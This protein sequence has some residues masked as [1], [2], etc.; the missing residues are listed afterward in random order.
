M[1]S[2]PRASFCALSQQEARLETSPPTTPALRRG[3]DAIVVVVQIP[4]RGGPDR[5]GGARAILVH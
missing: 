4:L 3:G 1:L 2:P 5:G